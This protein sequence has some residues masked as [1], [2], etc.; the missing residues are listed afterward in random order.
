MTTQTIFCCECEQDVPARLTQGYEIYPH[1]SDLGELPFW[2]HDDCG[3][4]VGC[5]HKTNQPTTPL[6]VIPTPELRKA[7]SQIHALMDPLW[8]SGK[9][10]RD[11]LYAAITDKLGWTYHTSNIRT[12][13]EVNVI[14]EHVRQIKLTMLS[15]E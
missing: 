7:R 8:K 14:M 4:Y 1:R 5:H 11:A 12:V 10:K 9:I 2:I 6:G 3:N 13:D 15:S